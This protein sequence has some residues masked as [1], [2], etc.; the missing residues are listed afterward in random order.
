MPIITDG[1]LGDGVATS[2]TKPR[3]RTAISIKRCALPE[4]APFIFH[5][6]I[7]PSPEPKA[8]A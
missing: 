8:P 6:R 4:R 3:W 2:T 7:E 1:W 5:Q